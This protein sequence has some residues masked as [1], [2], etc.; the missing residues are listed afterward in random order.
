MKRRQFIKSTA[1]TSL[2]VPSMVNG[3]P[4]HAHQP[5]GWIQE[6]LSPQVETD[7]VLVSIYLGGGNDGLN[8]VI[9]IDNYN[10]YRNARSNVAIDSNK[11]LSLN[12]NANS[13]FHPSMTGI[14]TLYNEGKVN[15]IQSV[16]YPNPDF[17]HFRATDI[18]TS[19]SDANRYIATGWAGRYLS[20]EFPGFPNGYPNASNPHPLALQIGANLPLMFLGPNAPMSMNLSNPDVF[21]AWPTGL[22]DPPTNDARG[23][24]LEYIRT[25]ARQSQKYADEVIKAYVAGSYDGTYPLNNYLADIFKAIARLIAGGLKTR[26]YLVQLYGFDTHSEQVDKANRHLGAHSNLLKL[27]SDAVLG[28]QRDIEKRKLENRVLSMTFSEF[29]RRIKSND[30]VGTDHGVAAPMFVIGSNVQ[31]GIIGKNPDIPTNL[32]VNDNIAMQFDFRSV[33][34]SILKDW[35]CISDTTAQKILFTNFQTLPIVNKNCA[36]TS[37]EEYNSEQE[38]IVLQTYPNPMV[39]QTTV[40]IKVKS[41]PTQIH[42]IDPEGKFVKKIFSGKLEEGTHK[43]NLYNE[44]FSPGNYYIYLVQ[45]NIQKTVMLSILR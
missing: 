5:E 26:M 12:G 36:S 1:A 3:I 33:Y 18:W 14:Q 32:T 28:F 24:E 11:I 29:G 13:G 9:P 8:T 35:F 44:N 22:Q 43:F 2:V 10:A 25:I 17:S 4:V 21:K 38:S 19:A 15:V 42:L 27:L 23:K 31:S 34:A 6:L 20:E 41:G 39:D 7:K 45:K 30:S 16:S 40:T 37:I